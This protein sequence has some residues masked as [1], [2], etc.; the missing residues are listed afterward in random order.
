MKARFFVLLKLRFSYVHGRVVRCCWKI[1]LLEVMSKKPVRGTYVLWK[2][3][4]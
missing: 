2:H 4:L 3:K 1:L